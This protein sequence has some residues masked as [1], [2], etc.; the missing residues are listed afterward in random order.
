MKFTLVGPGDCT[1]PPEGYGPVQV[2]IWDMK[3]TLEKFG[4]SVQI[5]NTKDDIQIMQQIE[6][7]QPDFIHF[8][9]HINFVALYPYIQ[10]PCAITSHNGYLPRLELHKQHGYSEMFNLIGKIQPTLFCLA[11]TSIDLFK[12]KFNFPEEKLFLTPNGVNTSIFNHTKTP[13]HPNKSLY[14]GV[15]CPRKR[16]HLFQ[17]IDSLW[18]VAPPPLPPNPPK[19]YIGY[20]K[21]ETIH[22]EITNYG[23]LVILSETEAQ[24]PL[25]AMEALAAGLGIVICE[26]A[27]PN[28]DTTKEF[29]TVIPEK[30]ITD[31]SYIEKKI[32]ENRKYSLQHRKDI[33]EYSKIFDW[34]NR[35][36]EY[37]LPAVESVI[38]SYKKT[39]VLK[40]PRKGIFKKLEKRRRLEYL[41]RAIWNRIIKKL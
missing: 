37:Y 17:D 30:R 19:N 24:V 11:Q 36:Q 14:I 39:S 27:T 20:W 4:H 1:I 15:I 12:N 6:S 3:Q 21:R 33:L 8:H 23:N 25:V 28:V 13:A 38:K 34:E 16:Q 22:K 9:D 41:I 31:L 26:W 5:I 32:I 2:I 35:L 40:F 10:Y 18:F 7:F 29:V